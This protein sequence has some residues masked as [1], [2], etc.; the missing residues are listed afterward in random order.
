MTR[1]ELKTALLF[2]KSCMERQNN[3]TCC[4]QCNICDLI[5]MAD[6]EIKAR[7][8]GIDVFN[9]EVILNPHKVFIP[10][11]AEEIEDLLKEIEDETK[12]MKDKSKEVTEI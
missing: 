10:I 11:I 3:S 2:G 5:L 12:E 9:P 6:S 7:I 4:E 8:N 1:R